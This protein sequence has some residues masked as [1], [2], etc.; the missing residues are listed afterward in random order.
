MIQPQRNPRPAR[1]LPQL[2]FLCLTFL[3]AV[4][5]AYVALR[6]F[7]EDAGGSEIPLVITVEVIITTTPLPP[8]VVTAAPA[9]APRQQVDVPADIAAETIAGG[10]TLDP[11]AL[12]ARDAARAT[13]TVTTVESL[14]RNTSNCLIITLRSGEAPYNIAARN[15]VDLELLMEVNQLTDETARYLKVGDPLIVP[16]PGCVVGGV[17]ADGSEDLIVATQAPEPTPTPVTAQLAVAAVEGL[18]D[19][20]R[21]GIRLR[22]L[23]ADIIISDWTLTDSDGNTFQFGGALLMEGAEVAVYTRTGTSTG[24]AWFWGR[25]ESV[26]QA[27]ETLTIRDPRGQHLLTLLIPELNRSE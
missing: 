25:D 10:P 19:I 4:A 16:V 26:W 23:G 9:S 22:N 3:A 27:G 8:K 12:G 18:G 20:T 2:L 17:N 5:G 13:P 11:A 15:F 24:S 7:G 14:R 6:L 1:I 21:E